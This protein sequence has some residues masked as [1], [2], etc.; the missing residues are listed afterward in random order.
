MS[1]FDLLH[2]NAVADHN[3]L[4]SSDAQG[5]VFANSRDVDFA[6]K[7]S[8]KTSAQDLCD[9][10]NGKNYGKAHVDAR[11]PEL[12][13]VFVIIHTPITQHVIFSLS[14]FMLCLSRLFKVEYDGWGSVVQPNA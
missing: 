7:T 9:F 12:I 8:D 14:G 13:W 3:L 4:E 5:D 1:L 6:F 11:D 10:V 2:E